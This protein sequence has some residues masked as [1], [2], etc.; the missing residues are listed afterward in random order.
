MRYAVRDFPALLRTP[1]GRTQLRRG[2]LHIAFPLLSPL[3]RMHRA[4]VARHARIVSVVGTYGKTTT[5][6]AV[7][8]ALGDRTHCLIG[9]NHHGF[10]A[11]AVLGIRPSHRHAVIE[12]G[13]S[14]VGEMAAYPRMLRP[15]VV[16]VTSIGTEHNRSLRNLEVTRRE[17]A[18][19]VRALSESG[20]AVLNGDD[21]NVR[22]MAGQTQAR[23]RTFGFG[24]HNH[25]RATGV[26]LDWPH[27]TRFTLHADG[28]AR[29]VRSRL[30]GR[31]MIY[32]LLASVAVA[33]NEGVDLDDAVRRIEE[34]TPTPGRMEPVRLAN[35][36]WILRDDH[37]SGLET[38]DLAL[39][40]FA[41][42]PAQRRIVVLGD[43]SEPP[44]SQGPIYRR[45]G[46]R[47]AQTAERAV[48]VGGS[49]RH[50]RPGA[51]SGGLT[52]PALTDAAT[53]E[54]ATEVLAAELRA[55]DVVLI[56]G[57]DTQRLDRIS[58]ALS[59]RHVGC[60]AKHCTAHPR[61]A[62]CPMLERG[63]GDTRVVT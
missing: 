50:Y 18:E 11:R 27:G 1:V 23:L 45:L 52:R 21:P 4:T 9:A 25:V 49:F 15:D 22:W 57:R 44:G 20:V 42:I 12:I 38:I 60:R 19:M 39:D 46:H 43:V 55:G 56:K 54:T 13:I 34:V 63:W 33:L 48:F 16:V 5:A 47:V 28:R 2:A 3:A 58:L 17:K 7:T 37:K 41:Q 62:K 14:T 35:G 59:G 8:A 29:Q 24:R 30:I 40:V 51:K 36:A 53:V 26:E 10:V 32:P 31:H 61:C 6:E